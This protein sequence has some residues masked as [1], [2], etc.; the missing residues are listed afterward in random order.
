LRTKT[1]GFAPDAIL[2]IN[3]ARGSDW[4]PDDL[5]YGEFVEL[6]QTTRKLLTGVR[7]I[8][9]SELNVPERN[10]AAGIDAQELKTRADQAA[11]S[12]REIVDQLQSELKSETDAGALR[13]AILKASQFGTAAPVPLSTAGDAPADREVLTRQL[14]SIAS[15][16]AQ[17]VTG[18]DNATGDFDRL[19]AIFGNS[20]VVLPRFS[21]ANAT[22]LQQA[23]AESDAIQDGDPLNAVTWF[24][25]AAR[26]RPG[27]ARL[28]T[29]LS[30]AEVLATGEKL[31]LRVAQLPFA[32]ND[33]WVALPLPENQE[34]SPSR[35]SL[36]VQ[37]APDLDVTQTMAGVLIDE[38]VELVPNSSETTGLVFQYDQPGTSPPQCILLAVPPD[39]DAPWNLWSLQQVLLETLDQALIRS[40][41]PDTLD[42]VGHYL[43]GL[44]FAINSNGEA[45]STDLTKA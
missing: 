42:E 25:R 37:A 34:L 17:R 9:G 15:D 6:L 44:Y 31:N 11:A 36:V 32:R 20:F 4:S 14:N 26:V 8:D 12:L 39:L 13:E 24:Q 33:R 30:Y 28:N 22:E 45:V 7:G 5:S 21:A 16:L 19:R 27:A 29:A 23:L 18:L 38:W 43:P 40:V 3:P 2:R 35:F 1:D 10:Q 41:D